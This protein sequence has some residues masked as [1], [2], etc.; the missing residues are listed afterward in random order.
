MLL[1]AMG[2]AEAKDLGLDGG[3]LYDPVANYKRVHAKYWDWGN[4]RKPQPVAASTLGQPSVSA[5]PTRSPVATP[6]K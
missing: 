4:D 6:S 2:R 1:R 3:P 5:V